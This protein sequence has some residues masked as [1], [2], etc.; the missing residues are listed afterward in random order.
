[1]PSADPQSSPYTIAILGGGIA[2]LCLAIGL[3]RHGVP[4]HLYESAHAF[5]EVGA[6]ISFGPNSIRAMQLLDPKVREKYELLATG[7]KDG[8]GLWLEFRMGCDPRLGKHRKGND[9]RSNG[10]VNG[11]AVDGEETATGIKVGDKILEVV[12]TVDGRPFSPGTV[13]RASFL[14]EL[15]AL[16]PK[17]TVSF[18]HRVVAV[19]DLGAEGV[20]IRFAHGATATA[21]AAVGCDGI[22]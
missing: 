8:S 19:D 16:I 11:D 3:Q 2:G 18:D 10:M 13:H 9:A 6:G 20:R 22:S 5:A 1:M 17:E 4:F 7:N 14:D 15:V 12:S 21:D